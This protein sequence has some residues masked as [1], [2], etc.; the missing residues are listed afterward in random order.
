G[1][2]HFVHFKGSHLSPK[3]IGGS[4]SGKLD[5]AGNVLFD[6]GEISDLP[7]EMARQ[8]QHGVLEFAGAVVQRTFAETINHDRGA[9]RDGRDQKYAAKRKPTDRAAENGSPEANGGGTVC[10]H[11]SRSLSGL[12][13]EQPFAPQRDSS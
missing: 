9:D 7:V 4:E 10:R 3:N 11:R 13:P 5:L 12:S 8:Q 6:G 2:Q 1:P